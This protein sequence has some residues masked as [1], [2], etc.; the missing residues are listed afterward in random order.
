VYHFEFQQH[1]SAYSTGSMTGFLTREANGTKTSRALFKAR[2]LKILYAK[3][4]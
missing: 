4:A 1:F 3:K 2:Q